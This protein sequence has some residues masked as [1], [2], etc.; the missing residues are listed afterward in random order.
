MAISLNEYDVGRDRE[1][2]YPNLQTCLSLTVVLDDGTLLGTHMTAGTTLRA[3]EYTCEYFEQQRAGANI[4]S[5]LLIGNVDAW[6]LKEES[7]LRTG[8]SLRET[9]RALMN[10]A[11]VVYQYDTALA[12][13]GGIGAAAHLRHK[14][15]AYPF[16]DVELVKDG[17]WVIFAGFPADHAAVQNLEVKHIY[18][19]SL[20]GGQAGAPHGVLAPHFVQM[21]RAIGERV[22]I[23]EA[24]MAQT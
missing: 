10:T 23:E 7:F 17:D 4:L 5:M 2:W 8:G 9:L 6:K 11:C 19:P 13:A 12:D 24:D 20:L 15:G 14:G 21:V 3:L 16:P 22:Q 18:E 1:I